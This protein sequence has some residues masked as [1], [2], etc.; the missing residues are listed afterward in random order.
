MSHG[1]RIAFNHQVRR[2][3]LA[4]T[5]NQRVAKRLA[6]GQ[7][8]KT[9]LFHRTDVHEDIFAAAIL[10]DEA[11]ALLRVEK[12]Y[13]AFAFANNLGG[14]LRPGSAAETAATAAAKAV[15]TAAE[16]ITATAETIAATAKAISTTAK[17]IT[18]AKAAVQTA[19]KTTI[20][21]IKAATTTLTAPPSIKTHP[22]KNFLRN[23]V[24]PDQTNSGRR[25]RATEI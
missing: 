11:K 24:R 5:I 14:H 12:L 9:S 10:H 8:S 4:A 22:S 15:T 16:A 3:N 23:R 17:A 21:L 25:T 20:A 6:F 18:T 1:K 19:V 13:D 2:R 7:T